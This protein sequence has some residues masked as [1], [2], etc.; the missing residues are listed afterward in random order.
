MGP[1]PVFFLLLY[2]QAK[3]T[4]PKHTSR[5]IPIE[6][7]TMSFFH[8]FYTL[9]SINYWRSSSTSANTKHL[10]SY[11][12]LSS[13]YSS[14]SSM[15]QIDSSDILKKKKNW[16]KYYQVLCEPVESSLPPEAWV[17]LF[18]TVAVIFLIHF[19]FIVFNSVF[20]FRLTRAVNHHIRY[21]DSYIFS[22]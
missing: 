9:V 16:K 13:I 10:K 20:I 12:W 15:K 22:T 5:S 7:S 14:C 8:S 1:G 18:T 2:F 21:A 19:Y 3:H 11:F 4:I 17:F 6:Y